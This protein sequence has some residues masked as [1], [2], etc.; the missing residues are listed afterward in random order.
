MINIL[1]DSHNFGKRVHIL[2]QKVIKPR[3]VIWEYLFLSKKSPLRILIE[4]NCRSSG[5][6]SPFSL[7]PNLEVEFSDNSSGVIDCLSVDCLNP[8]YSPS[9]DE[10]K[11]IGAVIAMAFWFG[12]GDLHHENIIIGR[13]GNE[14]IC[15]PIDIEC[16][17]D[18]LT[19]IKQNLLLPSDRISLN[20][21]GLAKILPQILLLPQANRFHLVMSFVENINLLNRIAREVYNTIIQVPYLNLHPI[22]VIVRDTAFYRMVDLKK[23]NSNLFGSELDQLLRGDIPYYFRLPNKPEI[24][25]WGSDTSIEKAD[26]SYQDFDLPQ[27]IDLNVFQEQSFLKIKTTILSINNLATQ[28][29]LIS[30]L[31]R[32]DCLGVSFDNNTYKFTEH[33]SQIIL[34]NHN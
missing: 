31:T 33:D 11:G 15:F 1:G 18:H 23:S 24:F 20:M 3:S 16:I 25:F 14:L 17:F 28:L 32:L 10:I 30:K 29:G 2:N 13:N 9:L 5:I 26:F 21:C 27:P 12:I 34:S 22:R 4:D 19:H 8:S 7:A 6:T